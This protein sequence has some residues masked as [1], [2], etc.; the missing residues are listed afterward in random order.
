MIAVAFSLK[1]IEAV[2]IAKRKSDGVLFGTMR[3]GGFRLGR[4]LIG[5]CALFFCAAGI[6]AVAMLMCAHGRPPSRGTARELRA[7]FHLASPV[8]GSFDGDEG[9]TAHLHDAGRS[10]A[11]NQLVE[12]RFGDVMSFAE[13][14][15]G[16]G[17]GIAYSG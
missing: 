16:E 14:D 7:L 2:R 5:A 11:L 1:A 17:E 8:G 6:L 15:D 4:G 13:L 10:A 3:A 12:G 9:A